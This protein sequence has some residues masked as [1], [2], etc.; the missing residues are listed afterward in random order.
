M[1]TIALC[2][3]INKFKN[4]KESNLRGCVN[5]AHAMSDWIGENYDIYYISEL[6]DKVATRD[7][8]VDALGSIVDIAN[9]DKE[10][11]RIIF[12]LSSHGSQIVDSSEDPDED[13]RLDEC[14]I[15]YDTATDKKGF[16]RDS[17]IVDD[18]FYA[19]LRSV[20]RSV[21]V[22]LFLD[23]C[24]S[25]TGTRMLNGN[26]PRFIPN[27]TF[28]YKRMLST[29]RKNKRSMSNQVLWA[30]CKDNQTSADAY[31]DGA[32]HGAG[33]FAFLKS[34]GTIKMRSAIIRDMGNWMKKN[35]MGQTPQL[36]ASPAM[37]NTIML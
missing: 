8:I 37:K 35:G 15:C 26:N 13:D 21:I 6:I 16:V 24:H 25:G 23:T 19:L 7:N 18:D 9:T 31:I 14:F 1:K 27:P 10:V 12:S 17:I 11:G 20:H 22:E 29:K 4:F 36:E 2:V 3:G 5:D 34:F 30:M 28:G 32:Y 33:T